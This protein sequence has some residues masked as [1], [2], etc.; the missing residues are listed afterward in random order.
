[1]LADRFLEVKRKISDADDIEKFEPIF[2][3]MDAINSGSM[4]AYY[5][6]LP[7]ARTIEIKLDG[8][9][10]TLDDQYCLRDQC[11]CYEAVLMF[12][13][14]DE[15]PARRKRKPVTVTVR[16]N[17]A[18]GMFSREP[19]SKQNPITERLCLA[20]RNQYPD[21][22]AICAK[23][24]QKLMRL[25]D[26]ARGRITA[27]NEPSQ[28]PGMESTKDTNP[29][30]EISPPKPGRNEPCPCGSGKKYKKC[31]GK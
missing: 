4:V 22:N 15:R 14:V 5:E 30:P 9:I 17:Y 18:T 23:R 21:L 25:L 29:R 20:F 24:Q 1:M 27:P 6:I 26:K 28:T 8:Q 2:Q 10:W 19:G 16:F 7:Y 12:I 11:N 13:L 31:C 3:D